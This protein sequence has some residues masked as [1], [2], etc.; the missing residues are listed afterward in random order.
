[1]KQSK[2]ILA[3][4]KKRGKMETKTNKTC[5]VCRRL[6]CYC[7]TANECKKCHKEGKMCDECIK[8]R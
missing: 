8:D 3:Y 6:G 2:K 7:G 4:D 5:N 1:M